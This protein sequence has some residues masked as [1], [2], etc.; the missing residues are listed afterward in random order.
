MKKRISFGRFKSFRD[1]FA[2]QT[3]GDPENAKR[4]LGSFYQTRKLT[5]GISGLLTLALLMI[6]L[7]LPSNNLSAA[8]ITD[9]LRY[10][11]DV[12][13]GK[14]SD[15]LRLTLDSD[16]YDSVSANFADIRLTD[17]NGAETPFTVKQETVNETQITDVYHPAKII[18]LTKL[19]ANRIDICIEIPEDSKNITGLVLKTPSRNFEKQADVSGSS[20]MK[21]W[22]KTTKEQTIFDYSEIVGLSNTAIKLSGPAFK[23]YKI[24]IANFAENRKSPRTELITEKRH[25]ADFSQIEKLTI[26][27]EP[28]KINE[29]GFLTKSEK[30]IIRKSRTQEYPVSEFSCNDDKDETEIFI[31][32]KKEPLT[33]FSLETVSNNFSRAVSVDGSN[34]KKE[35]QN[36]TGHEKI[37][38]IGI[39]GYR[40]SDLNMSIPESRFKFY[41]I[42]ISNGNA[43]P[44]KFSTI[45]AYGNIYSLELI[46]PKTSSALSVYYGGSGIPLPSYDVNEILDKLKNPSYAEIKPG[47]QKDNPLY[48][49]ASKN[50]PFLDSK[51]FFTSIVILMV[52]LLGWILYRGFKKID[53]MESE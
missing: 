15:I 17:D 6:V 16:I 40:E 43:P 19:D 14:D 45:H 32:T 11:K 47:K 5:P 23:Y 31:S 18:S 41:R 12:Q 4:P 34:D 24:S 42:K 51:I 22:R 25:G 10:M 35:W 28:L 44:V 36:L 26:N 2:K 39:S 21:T 37:T 49:P 8:G 1:S 38:R 50:Q 27:S 46:N 53:T 3:L 52:L 48:K 13:N 9:N 20:D 33:L 30:K 7:S 29:I